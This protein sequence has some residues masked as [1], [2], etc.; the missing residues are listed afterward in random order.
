MSDE[1]DF[2]LPWVDA[3]DKDWQKSKDYYSPDL[4]N[5]YDND[6]GIIRYRDTKTL[7]YALRSIEK[8][9]PW[10]NKIH[11]ITNGQK[12][13]W[14]N[15]DHPKINLIIHEELYFDKTHLPTFNSSSIEMNLANLKNVSE[16]FIYLNDDFLIFN[17]LTK[18]RFFVD[19]KPVDFL[20]H[21]WIP[22]N[23]I[24]QFLRDDSS[25]V[26]S[27]NNNIKLINSITTPSKIKDKR[28]VFF[29]PTYS[30]K[31]KISNFLLL[32]LYRRYFF[33]SHWHN[34]QP[35][36]LSV[37]KEVYERFKKP[38]LECSKNRFRSDNDLT[39]YL[40]RYYH[41]A[42]GKFYPYKYNDFYYANI[43]SYTALESIL[44]ELKD[45]NF[46]FVSIYDNYRDEESD[47]ILKKLTNFLE[48]KFPEKASFEL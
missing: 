18:D 40:Y 35:Y 26:K 15:F 7:K 34:A 3:N 25:W 10:Y 19:D 12:P 2:V 31:D 9:C 16:K 39:Q 44:E 46:N 36:T 48:D 33:I 8:Y 11:L 42:T 20:V 17:R 21:G 1:I 38:M 27:L 41:L 37:L 6:K 13:E 43:T 47:D 29:N 4:C 45:A 28:N 5:M 30:M 14:L 32:N 24:Y 23:R 22:R